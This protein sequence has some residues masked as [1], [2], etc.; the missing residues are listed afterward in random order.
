MTTIAFDG[1]TLAADRCN[2]VGAMR[3]TPMCKIDGA[4]DPLRWFASCGR[5]DDGELVLQWITNGRKPD[6]RPKLGDDFNGLLVEF[7]PEFETAVAVKYEETLIPLAVRPP[8]AIGSGAAYAMAAMALGKSAAEAV[9]LASRLDVFTGAR[10]VASDMECLAKDIYC[11]I[12]C[13]SQGKRHPRDLCFSQPAGQIQAFEPH[14]EDVD[15]DS[16]Y[17]W[18][19]RAHGCSWLRLTCF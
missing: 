3:L 2:V 13:F 17:T 8:F 15:M 10:L 1:K 18:H 6:E 4:G 5:V 9:E 12:D 11:L 7:I 14:F 16:V 19:V